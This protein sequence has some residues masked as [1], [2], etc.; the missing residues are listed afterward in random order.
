MCETFAATPVPVTLSA[1]LDGIVG[2][3]FLEEFCGEVVCERHK[4]KKIVFSEK[5]QVH[6][7]DLIL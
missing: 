5:S 7:P 1:F 4:I 3:R 6:P 2:K